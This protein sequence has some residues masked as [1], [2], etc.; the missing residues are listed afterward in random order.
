M[1]DRVVMGLMIGTSLALLVMLV[2][3]VTELSRATRGEL[4]A[5]TELATAERKRADLT[6]AYAKSQADARKD[7]V[8]ALDRI[9]EFEAKAASAAARAGE[10]E[11]EAAAATPVRAPA[12]PAQAPRSTTAWLE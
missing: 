5:K 4:A 2:L 3:T 1:R 7:A 8:R 10:C 11:A 9:M 12:R 6:D